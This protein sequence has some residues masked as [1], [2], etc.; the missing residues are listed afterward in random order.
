MISKCSGHMCPIHDT[1]FRFV[2]PVNTDGRQDWIEPEW[3]AEV[4]G[5]P[6]KVYIQK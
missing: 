6:N 2:A 5:C 4:M 1:C 3:D